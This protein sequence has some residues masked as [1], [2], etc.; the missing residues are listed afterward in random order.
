[1]NVVAGHPPPLLWHGR[2]RRLV[3]LGEGGLLIGVQSDEVY[4]QAEIRIEAGDR[5]LV[6]TDGVP[7]AEDSSGQSFGEFRLPKFIEAN[8]DLS[9]QRFSEVLL[10]EV[11]AWSRS[12]SQVK[13]SDDITFLVIDFHD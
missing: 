3:P 10:E 5:L 9:A 8:A 13:R 6:C 12:G 11:R 2:A 4:P 7:E 1:M